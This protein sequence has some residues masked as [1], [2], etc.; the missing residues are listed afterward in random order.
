MTYITSFERIGIQEGIQQGIQQGE[1]EL[2][3]ID[4][5]DDKKSVHVAIDYDV[6]I[7]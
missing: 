4:H 1:L 3:E 6:L 5:D 2:N 7:Y